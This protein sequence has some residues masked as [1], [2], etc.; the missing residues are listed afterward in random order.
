MKEKYQGMKTDISKEISP[1]GEADAPTESVPVIVEKK[2][3]APPSR[4]T[5]PTK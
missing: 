3:Q 1:K 4:S 2:E 5:P